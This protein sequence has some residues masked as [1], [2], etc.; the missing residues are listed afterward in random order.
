MILSGKALAAEIEEGLKKRVERLGF[1]P[2]LDI[3]MVGDD[4]ASRTYVEKKLNKAVLDVLGTI[5]KNGAIH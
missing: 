3:I 2:G 5:Y 1:A 4:P